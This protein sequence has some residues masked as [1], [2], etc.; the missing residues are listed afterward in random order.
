MSSS[1]NSFSER[2]TE[3]SLDLTSFFSPPF[4]ETVYSVDIISVP[5]LR[6]GGRRARAHSG[7]SCPLRSW[8]GGRTQPSLA[9]R[10]VCG[11][12][13]WRTPTPS[14]SS[15]TSDAVAVSRGAESPP[16]SQPFQS[17][18]LFLSFSGWI[19]VEVD[20]RLTS[21]DCGRMIL[22][23]TRDPSAH[24][25]NFRARVCLFRPARWCPIAP[26]R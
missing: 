9:L 22:P 25:Q 21:Q 1:G 3:V 15:V 2:K 12:G 16:W 11:G 5:S 4:L 8:R 14:D 18:L 19:S 7:C 6:V 24:A 13:C 26:L 23:R 20:G 10:L 17:G